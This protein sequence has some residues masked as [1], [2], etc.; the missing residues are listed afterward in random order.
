MA[1]VTCY[2][3]SPRGNAS[4]SSPAALFDLS[5]R[6]RIDALI[7]GFEDRKEI[8]QNENPWLIPASYLDTS[9]EQTGP[10][11]YFSFLRNDLLPHVVQVGQPGFV[12]HMTGRIPRFVQE[13]NALMVALNQNLVK[14]ETSYA[15]SFMQPQL[16]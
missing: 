12:G 10:E 2:D 1:D 5:Y 3:A 13:L 7:G 6:S 15:A 9:A 11:E 14:M 8:I 16:T 4:P